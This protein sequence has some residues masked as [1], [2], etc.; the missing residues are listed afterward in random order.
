MAEELDWDRFDMFGRGI[1]LGLVP[2]LKLRVDV[3]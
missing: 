3:Q 1:M 2:I